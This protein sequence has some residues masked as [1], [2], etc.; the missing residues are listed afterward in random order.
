MTD[1]DKQNS[2]ER[3]K[4][5]MEKFRAD[6]TE[7]DKQLS[8]EREK[9]RVEKFKANMTEEEIEAYNEKDRLRKVMFRNYEESIDERKLRL[10][11]ESVRKEDVKNE[12]TEEELAD[13]RKFHR[14]EM[15][16]SR[17]NLPDKIREYDKIER[18]HKYRLLN[19]NLSQE[20]QS[21]LKKKAR[22]GMSLLRKKGRLIKFVKKS[23]PNKDEFTDWE[24]YKQRSHDNS[25]FLKLAKPDIVKQI[26]E[27][28]RIEKERIKMEK[29]EKERIETE[30]KMLEEATRELRYRKKVLKEKGS[31]R[32]AEEEKE[33][34]ELEQKLHETDIKE[35]KENDMER[36]KALKW[37]S[38]SDELDY[39]YDYHALVTT[40]WAKEFHQLRKK[41]IL[42]YRQRFP[43]YLGSKWQ[44]LYNEDEEEEG[45]HRLKVQ[46]GWGVERE[47]A[48]TLEIKKKE[49]SL[50]IFENDN[51]GSNE[52]S[53]EDQ[54]T[55]ECSL[56][57]SKEEEEKETLC[58][59]EKLR[60][61]NIQERQQFMAECKYF[62][63]L[64]AIKVKIGLYKNK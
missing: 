21:Q 2:G 29:L 61:K 46:Y 40:K 54:F 35:L 13:Q 45:C 48:K 16:K 22:K 23:K 58:D 3:A 24:E 27:K 7:E 28:E 60:E 4:I 34:L 41:L 9:V 39:W 37:D 56:V 57:D 18:K 62:D 51:N 19:K 33:Y 36:I 31:G 55:D 53:E 42:G 50:R 20:Q 64:N 44:Q 59:Y 10:A 11:K 17:E 30:K 14:K 8:R 12:M 26:N 25:T 63:D 6:M 49:S 1:E 47:K 43:W 15:I 32:T 5:R 38:L 52:D